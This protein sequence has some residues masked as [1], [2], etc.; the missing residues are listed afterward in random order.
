M[1]S[2]TQLSHHTPKS[3]TL[4]HGRRLLACGFTKRG[5]LSDTSPHWER[6]TTNQPAEWS[7]PSRTVTG[8]WSS[9]NPAIQSI[10]KVGRNTS[11]PVSLGTVCMFDTH[12]LENRAEFLQSFYA[13]TSLAPINVEP[14]VPVVTP[15]W[16][17]LSEITRSLGLQS[18]LPRTPRFGYAFG[19]TRTQL[20][21]KLLESFG[22]N[23]DCSESPPWPSALAEI[24]SCIRSKK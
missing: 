21:E 6:T 11:R 14:Q 19:A 2:H 8:R 23:F 18:T 5:F 4:A 9:G 3:L 1:Q 16:E 22:D 13:R 10:R 12:E 15:S 24:R 17:Q 7:Y 20:A